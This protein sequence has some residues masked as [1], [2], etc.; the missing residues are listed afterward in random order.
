MED[1]YIYNETM[2]R[3][4]DI[5]YDHL[6]DRQSRDFYIERIKE[7]KEPVLEI[8]TGTGRIFLRGLEAGADIYGIDVSTNMLNYLK[9]R[10]PEKE[11]YR[12]DHQDVRDFRLNK[13]FDLIIAP[14]R[15]FS[16]VL[17][18]DDQ[19]AALRSIREHLTDKGRFIF[20]V[21][22]PKADR[23][24]SETWQDLVIDLEYET[25]K[26]LQRFDIVTPDYIH[27]IQHI[28]FKFFWDEENGSHQE[29]I[30]FPFRYFFRYELEHLLTRANLK[31]E[32]MY[33][34]FYG[35]SLEEVHNEFLLVCSK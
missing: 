10:L 13:K 8:G 9:S 30:E 26:R 31:I 11:H 18:I 19:L 14:F 1:S 12:L 25:G 5:I 23:I 24:D 7:C 32:K 4:Y 21:F 20:D 29:S 34:D 35:H 33:G 27:Q 22:V 17:T 6:L 28:T 16:H 15:M 3:F 2:V